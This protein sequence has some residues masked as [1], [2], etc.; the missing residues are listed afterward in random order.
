MAR[1]GQPSDLVPPG[2]RTASIEMGPIGFRAP[3]DDDPEMAAFRAA[4]AA[5]MPFNGMAPTVDPA[6]QPPAPSPTPTPRPQG[7]VSSYDAAEQADREA[8]LAA[9]ADGEPAVEFDESPGLPGADFSTRWA[10]S[11]GVTPREQR[12][13]FDR[14][15]GAENVRLRG[16]TI[17]FKPPGEKK[18]RKVDSDTLNSV[19][20][21]AADLFAD[22]GGPL[23]EAGSGIA[24]GVALA[25]GGL[26]AAALGGAI[27]AG[28][29]VGVRRSL[30]HEY[31]GRDERDAAGNPVFDPMAEAGIQALFSAA[32]E[33][34]GAALTG[35]ARH[36]NGMKMA[37]RMA[38]DA[39]AEA[40][41]K[42]QQLLVD[43]IDSLRHYN[44]KGLVS[45]K[46]AL[47]AIPAGSTGDVFR[48]LIANEQDRL[49][50]N[51][52]LWREAVEGAAGDQRFPVT[53]YRESLQAVLKKE[54][55]RFDSKTGQAVMPRDTLE[56]T[57]SSARYSEPAAPGF[58]QWEHRSDNVVSLPANPGAGGAPFS[59]LGGGG[60]LAK[61]VRDYNDILAADAA[62]G[63]E[64]HQIWNLTTG[65]Q[66]PAW[67]ADELRGT[68]QAHLLAEMRRIGNGL[69]GDRDNMALKVLGEHSEEFLQY[70]G[71]LSEYHSRVDGLRF[72]QSL[73]DNAVNQGQPM[74]VGSSS[75]GQSLFRAHK[76]DAI[77]AVKRLL[78]DQEKPQIW[79]SL[80]GD[81]LASKVHANTNK[82]T[83]MLD[84]EGFL[85]STL[86]SLGE[87]AD[88]VFTKQE[89]RALRMMPV[90]MKRILKATEN[91]KGQSSLLGRV[92]YAT[93]PNARAAARARLIFSMSQADADLAE[94]MLHEGFNDIAMAA[95]GS[96][97][98]EWVKAKQAF[99][100]LMDQAK[101]QKGPGKR[102]FLTIPMQYVAAPAARVGLGV[103][104]ELRRDLS[105]PNPMP[106]DGEMPEIDVDT[107]I[108]RARANAGR[109]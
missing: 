47:D 85:S 32:G 87:A 29:G 91:R 26:P 99:A 84:P 98:L 104:D 103:A 28:A 50:S 76:E 64:A 61:M 18:F 77:R 75:F 81:W 62:G 39:A 93:V 71:S 40:Y 92:V 66:T 2:P 33:G 51:V 60:P 4:G 100:D 31:G 1:A 88:D 55:V 22:M 7:G 19:G 63:M 46:A 90:Q 34:A 53:N 69:A 27:G 67:A 9:G 107:E 83:G 74:A 86:N 20:E 6:N 5:P 23:V 80:R 36:L 8:F 101:T 95:R 30:F 37:P 94:Y 42:A 17:Y 11:M 108:E 48:G 97:R 45:E 49:G 38:A 58:S 10:A 24:G 59:S 16:S 109:N 41:G 68:H 35:L 96:E 65:Y 12:Q 54:G 79:D 21:L 44:S 105:V 78:H 3:A 25:R 72:L 43:A 13:F 57:V 106:G 56:E 14:K 89:Q 82:V 70:K 102:R 52:G 73:Y 15:Y